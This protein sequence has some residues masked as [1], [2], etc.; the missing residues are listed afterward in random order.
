MLRNKRTFRCET[1]GEDTPTGCGVGGGGGRGGGEGGNLSRRFIASLA[2][3]GCAARA[4]GYRIR[5]PDAAADAALRT[6]A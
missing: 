3:Q 5:S 2:G 4:E 1:A 6:R